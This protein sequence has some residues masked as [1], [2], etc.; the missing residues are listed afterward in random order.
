MSEQTVER[1]VAYGSLRITYDDRVLRPRE[2]TTL[3]SRWAAERLAHLSGPALELCCGA[4][5]IG[6]LAIALQQ[7]QLVC[8]DMSP[9]ACALARH[10]A[11][12]NGLGALVEVREGRAEDVL[13]PTERFGVAI[14][15]PPWVPSDQTGRYPED[16]LLA[17]DGGAD[18]LDV[19]RT[20][21]TVAAEHLLPHG[22]ALVQLGTEE[23]ARLLAGETD[24]ALRDVRRGERGVVGRFV[25]D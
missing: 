11:E 3:Q 23:Q 1:T 24:L 4:G 6:L 10:N 22:E 13:D 21:L 9:A 8:V 2:W 12:T 25:A 19:A 14:V 16:P 15:D 17:I 18:G 7:R 20:C 5:Q